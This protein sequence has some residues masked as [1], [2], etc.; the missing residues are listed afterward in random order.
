MNIINAGV[1]LGFTYTLNPT[2]YLNGQSI[3]YPAPFISSQMSS[4][5]EINLET[6]F[7]ILQ[8]KY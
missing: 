4:E 1:Q 7:K 5:R 6:S 2:L 3:I 8:Q